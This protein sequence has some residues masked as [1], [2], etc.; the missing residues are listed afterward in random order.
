LSK[1]GKS[2][3]VT[4]P[5]RATA[6]Y[7]FSARQ[8]E[9]D[10]AA[11]APSAPMHSHASVFRTPQGVRCRG[12]W[13]PDIRTFPQWIRALAVFG[14][15]AS[16]AAFA[17]DPQ[18]LIFAGS[19][20]DGEVCGTGCPPDGWNV[21]LWPVTLNYQACG[22]VTVYGVVPGDA[23]LFTNCIPQGQTPGTG[24]PSLTSITD[25]QAND[26]LTPSDD[27]SNSQSIPQL[28]G[29]SCDNAAAQLAMFCAP[30][31]GAGVIAKPNA[32]R[33]TLTVCPFNGTTTGS[34]PLYIW[35]KGA[36][37]PNPG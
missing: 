25:N 37:N 2:P 18:N 10:A 6:N 16:P 5:F 22:Q 30:A 28:V 4:F 11:D 19:F 20:E 35:W 34:S 23:F 3:R 15:A 33:F 27:C 26:Y 29:W 13:E 32:T 36:S 1:K 31:N 9:I 14:F 17:L 7:R 8:R 21:L 12:P 24:D